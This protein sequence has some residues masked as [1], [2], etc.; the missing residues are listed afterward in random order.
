M[1]GQQKLQGIILMNNNSNLLLNQIIVDNSIQSFKEIIPHYEYSNNPQSLVKDATGNI[2]WSAINTID[3]SINTI[4]NNIFS[5]TDIYYDNKRIG[6]GRK[7]L[8][9]YKIDLAIPQNNLMTAFHIGDGS[10]GFSFGNGT[11]QGFIPEIIGIGS[12]ENDAGLY[13]V[14]IAGNDKPSDIPL[15]VFDARSTYNTRLINRPIVGITSGNY[16]EYDILLDAN[17]NIK[18]TGDIIINNESLLEIIK[19]LQQQINVLQNKIT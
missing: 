14:G 3:L 7:P 4:V 2:Y 18:I 12:D 19:K 1:N 16:N 10:F 8:H 5:D 9:N 6:I 15:I 11:N 13:F 17:G